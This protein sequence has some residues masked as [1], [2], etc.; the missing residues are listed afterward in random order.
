MRLALQWRMQGTSGWNRKAAPVLLILASVAA[1][2]GTDFERAEGFY[3]RTDYAG[4]MK[5]LLTSSKDNSAASNA[6]IGKSYFMQ[7]QYKS[8]SIYLEKAVAEDPANA[9]YLRL[10]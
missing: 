9:E 6:L 5:T 2:A 3:Q 4:V 10:I 1:S 8:S 7:G